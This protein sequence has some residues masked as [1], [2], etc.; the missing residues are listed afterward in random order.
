MNRSRTT[1]VAGLLVCLLAIAGCGSSS[2]SSSGTTG[3]TTSSS[4]SGSTSNSSSSSTSSSPTSTDSTAVPPSDIKAAVE[5]CKQIISSETKLTSGAKE[6]LEGACEEA[7]KGNTAAVTQ[8]AREV[9]EETVDNSSLPT[10]AK[11]AAKTDCQKK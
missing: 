9:C 5:E 4:P 1:L 11:E 7:A 3:S 6:K 8:A 2:S 10:S